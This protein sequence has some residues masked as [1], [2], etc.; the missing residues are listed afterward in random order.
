MPTT[1]YTPIASTTLGSSTQS[2]SLTSIP[3]T[4]RDLILVIGGKFVTDGNAQNF[5]MRL[6]GVTSSVYT[7]VRMTGSGSAAQSGTDSDTLAYIGGANNG[8]DFVMRL[9]FMDYSVTD[10]HKTILARLDAP[11]F[12][13]HAS[14]QRFASTNAITS[15][16]M[17]T[18][19]SSI[20]YDAGTTFSLYGIVA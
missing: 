20:R 1:T 15:I 16:E 12:T 2:V 18:I 10:K 19:N 4:Y 14:A 17:F 9:Q 5:Y 8:Q 11:A 13:S 7:S 6:N 3:Q